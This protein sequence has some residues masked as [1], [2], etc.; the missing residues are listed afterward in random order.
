VDLDQQ[1]NLTYAFAVDPTS[2]DATVVDVL[3]PRSPVSGSE[4]ILHDV[5]DVAGLDRSSG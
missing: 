1:A 3:A 5:H 2:L 4:A